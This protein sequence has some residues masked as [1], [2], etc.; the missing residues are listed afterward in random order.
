MNEAQAPIQGSGIPP[1][2]IDGRVGV[3]LPDGSE[4]R[5]WPVDAAEAI[6]LHSASLVRP[7]EFDDLP[8]LP[9]TTR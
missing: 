5:M 1:P 8:A 9:P 4:A 6:R 2:G 7:M 3:Y